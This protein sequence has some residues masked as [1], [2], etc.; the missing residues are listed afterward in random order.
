M[1]MNSTSTVPL[2]GR[3]AGDGSVASY[4]EAEDWNPTPETGYFELLFSLLSHLRQILGE[5]IKID[6]NKFVI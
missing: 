2:K 5:C 4:S 3:P 6:H 1:Y